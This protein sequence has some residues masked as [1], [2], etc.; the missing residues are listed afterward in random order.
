VADCVGDPSS[1]RD[2]KHFPDLTAQIAGQDEMDR[3]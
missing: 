3:F 2:I 1:N